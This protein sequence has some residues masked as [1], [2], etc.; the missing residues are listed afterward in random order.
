VIDIYTT[1]EAGFI[2]LE[3]PLQNGYHIQ[4][5][6]ILE[7]VNTD[8]EQVKPGEIGEIVITDLGNYAMPLI[9][10]RTGDYGRWAVNQCACGNQWPLLETLEGRTGD[11][12]YRDDLSTVNPFCFIRLVD[13]I[14]LRQYQITQRMPGQLS[15]QYIPAQNELD[16][17]REIRNA[18]INGLGDAPEITCEKVENIGEPGQKVRN[19]LSRVIRT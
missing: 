2:G 6:I 18:I 10:Y 1:T 5:R 7:V 11:V 19:F 15:V 9:R 8:G 16:L 14:P 12:Y 4:D 17:G 13:Q 3:C